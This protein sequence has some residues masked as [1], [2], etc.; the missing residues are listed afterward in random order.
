MGYARFELV[1]HQV[2]VPAAMTLFEYLSVAV[3]IVL[4]LAI[5]RLADGLRIAAMS[6]EPYWVQT[7][8]IVDLLVVC[9]IHWWTSW[10]FR[11]ANWS[12]P[13]F[14][15][16]LLAP[17]ILYFLSATLWPDE[18]KSAGSWR[19]YFF[20]RRRIFF[21]A[22]L[23]YTALATVDGY[24]VLGA[25]LLEPAR[26][27]QLAALALAA[28]GLS[29]SSPRAHAVLVLAFTALLVIASL[30]LVYRPDSI[31]G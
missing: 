18:S 12:F 27:G 8:W 28:I 10:S 21:T 20:E 30:G 11:D 7:L 5:I 13:R 1:S 22:L 4:S 25:P 9:F 26:V 24:L 19:D 16:V 17:G 29:T 2:D 15:L 31:A 23:A 6:D 3:S 14:V